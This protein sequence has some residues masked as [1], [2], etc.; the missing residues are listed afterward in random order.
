MNLGRA[1]PGDPLDFIKR[2]IAQRQIRWTYHVNVRLRDRSISRQAVLE[3]VDSY[4]IVEEYPQDKY[5]PSYL[6]YAK[7]QSMVFHLLV[8]TD[9]GNDN[10]RVITAY[11]PD[12]EEW[13]TDSKQR[14]PT[15]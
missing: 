13:D 9:L 3:S 12:P 15:A 11:Q 10:V 7:Y 5:L 2:C 4:E 1:L 6:V 8:A 14:R